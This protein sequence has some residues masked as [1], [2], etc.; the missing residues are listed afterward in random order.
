MGACMSVWASHSGLGLTS[1]LCVSGSLYHSHPLGCTLSSFTMSLKSVLSSSLFSD[2][3]ET[4]LWQ[5]VNRGRERRGHL[6]TGASIG[7]KDEETFPGKGSVLGKT[8]WLMS[9]QAHLCV[10]QTSGTRE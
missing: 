5:A 2:L 3:L 1:L 4:C 10:P 7:H 8:V 9:W 6:A